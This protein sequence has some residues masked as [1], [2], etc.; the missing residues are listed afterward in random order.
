MNLQLEPGRLLL[1][2]GP[3][4]S[5]KSTLALVLA[6]LLRSRPELQLEGTVRAGETDLL[7]CT[8][9][10][11]ARKVG[12]L[13][14]EP[15]GQLF[16]TRVDTEIAFGPRNLNL[17]A[18]EVQQ[19]VRR[20][21]VATGV[22]DLLHRRP[23]ELS[24]GEKQRVALAAVLAME[25][26]GIVLDE[27]CASLDR[28]GALQLM[29]ILEGLKAA[30]RAVVVMEHRTEPVLPAADMVLLLEG[31]RPVDQGS[32]EVVLAD[33]ERLTRLGL[34]FPRLFQEAPWEEMI[35][36]DPPP[37]GEPLVI[38]RGVT[39]GPGGRTVL[40]ELDL[41][42]H[43]GET[44]ALVGDNGCGKTTLARVMSGLLRPRRGTVRRMLNLRRGCGFLLQDPSRQLLF[45]SVRREVEMGPRNMG[46]QQQD[47]IET[48]LQEQGLAA[49]A[50]RPVLNLSTG[51]RHRTAL[52]SVLALEPELII[53]DEPTRGQD[54][55][56]LDGTIARLRQ[57]IGRG[58]AILLITHDAKLV[59]RFADRAALLAQG[60]IRTQGR[61]RRET[62]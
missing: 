36:P 30:G 60:R 3:S 4:G 11:A 33:G 50:D 20:A 17:P 16:Q 8:P 1:V 54:W 59:F 58:G 24:G 15:A 52:A 57:G 53:L 22:Q 40:E 29:A 46:R 25:T 14:P 43:R 42:I 9:V 2:A 28:A 37:T 55:R 49:L 47:G 41:T 12:L 48:L 44:L 26:P 45:Q 62:R 51:E 19:R 5:G 13:L 27:P 6:G 10:E 7:R 32:P 23:S 34:R 18:D 31:G 56:H 21:A 61:P 38:L 39:A 35:E